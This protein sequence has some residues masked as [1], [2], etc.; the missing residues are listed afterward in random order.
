MA[1]KNSD[2]DDFR[3]EPN[4]TEYSALNAYALVRC[5]DFA[6]AKDVQRIE[7]QTTRWGFPKTNFKFFDKGGTQGFAIA[8]DETV[9]FAFRGTEPDELNDVLADADIDLTNGPFGALI[10]RGFVRA[11]NNVATFVDRRMR[12]YKR[13]GTRSVW[14]TGHSL[15]AAL[16]TLAA[17]SLLDTDEEVAG[18]YTFGSPRVGNRAFVRS[19]NAKLKNHYRM[20]YGKD[21][22]TRVAPRALKYAHAGQLTTIAKNGNISHKGFSE[23]SFLRNVLHS[24]DALRRLDLTS[25]E[26]HKIA[27]GYVPML[28]KRATA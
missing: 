22:V 19:L 13:S 9:I 23:A 1:K 26:D 7:K 21:F 18:L 28:K 17:A 24:L 25:I 14:F 8:N 12:K 20:V 27:T 3:F 16:A 10:H 5:S 11:L 2:S 4:A 6:Y 15:G